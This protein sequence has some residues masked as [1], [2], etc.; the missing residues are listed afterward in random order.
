MQKFV[1]ITVAGMVLSSHVVAAEMV[2]EM[3]K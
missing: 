3:V 1:L 2:W